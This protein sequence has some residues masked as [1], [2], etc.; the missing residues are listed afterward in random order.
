[1]SKINFYTVGIAFALL[2]G[3][4]NTYAQTYTITGI[5][6]DTENQ[7]RL[8][9]CSIKI[10]NTNFG[11][12]ADASGKF[13]INIHQNLPAQKLVVSSMGYI[14][15]TIPVLTTQNHYLIFLKPAQG[16]LNEVVVTGVGHWR[17]EG[18]A[19]IERIG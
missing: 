16:I 3:T 7:Q 18:L 8:S 13:S 11:I 19:L 2:A 6:K 4:I 15:D 17:G 5:V 12:T 1:M 9:F 10:L 14:T